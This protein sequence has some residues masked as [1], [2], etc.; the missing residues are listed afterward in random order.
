MLL[1]PARGPSVIKRKSQSLENIQEIAF[2]KADASFEELNHIGRFLPFFVHDPEQGLI[3]IYPI[4]PTDMAHLIRIGNTIE[5]N[6][7][8]T[9]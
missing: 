3:P 7:L 6:L 2:E 1:F 9:G 8:K 5:W 4:I